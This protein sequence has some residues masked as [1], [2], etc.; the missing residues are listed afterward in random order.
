MAWPLLALV[1]PTI[2]VGWTWMVGL[3]FDE[4]I[5]EYMLGD[6]QP[7][8]HTDIWSMHY[9]AMGVSLVIATV[10]IGLGIAFYAPPVLTLFDRP[11]AFLPRKRFSAEAV[12]KRYPGVYNFLAHKWYFDEL[13]D[14]LFV[15]PSLAMARLL[16][17]F[18]KHWLDGLVNGAAGMTAMLSRLEGVFDKF[19][20]DG[21][22]NLVGLATYT[23]GDWGRRLQTGRLRGYLMILALAFVGLCAGVFAWVV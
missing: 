4:P 16:S 8:P 21:L 3:P 15:R 14:A 9:Y 19:A 13:Y 11:L 12:A 7:V 20:V 5:L 6:G 1:V 18:D 17:G 2:F 23:L 22:V 10:G